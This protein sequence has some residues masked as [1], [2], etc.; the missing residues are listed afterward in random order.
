M[1]SRYDLS[2]YAEALASSGCIVCA[3]EYPESLS[4][5]YKI[6]KDDNKIDRDLIA[7]KALQF[8]T[9]KY[10]TTGRIG[11]VGHSLG[12]GLTMNYVSSDGNSPRCAI[13]GFRGINENI[14]NSSVLVIG[15]K[16]VP[17]WSDTPSVTLKD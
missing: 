9:K 11:F 13:A 2:K 14:Q 10:N 12:T 6:L 8:L 1:G 16:A 5:S 7:T 4:A 17:V 3:P 15:E